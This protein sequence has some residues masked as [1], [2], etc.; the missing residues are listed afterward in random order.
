MLLL[1]F[2]ALAVQKYL[3]PGQE[4]VATVCLVGV[5]LEVACS[6]LARQLQSLLRHMSVHSGLELRKYQRR[7]ALARDVQRHP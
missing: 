5:A 1:E 4:L 2:G 7:T 3:P 6:A